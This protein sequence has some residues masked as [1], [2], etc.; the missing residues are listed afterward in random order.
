MGC[1]LSDSYWS[2]RQAGPVSLV[3][4]VC[5]LRF[6]LRVGMWYDVRTVSVRLRRFG[7]EKLEEEA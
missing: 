6:D 1:W 5:F 4:L 3:G 7:D 2:Y